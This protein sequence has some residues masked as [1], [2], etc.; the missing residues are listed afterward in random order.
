[1]EKRMADI[2]PLAE[3]LRSEI[4][5][6]TTEGDQKNNGALTADVL[7][8]VVRVA[9]TGRDLILSLS[10]NPSNLAGMI[11]PPSSFFGIGQGGDL[12]DVSLEGSVPN[13]QAFS[14]SSPSENFGMVA[15]REIISAMKNINGS[16]AKLVEALAIAREK[17]LID[18][19]KDLEAQLGVGKPVSALPSTVKP[20]TLI[21][22]V[23]GLTKTTLQEAKS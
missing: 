2:Q 13:Y 12:G 22:A 15:M 18:V 7:A 6:L 8:R 3:A 9:K 5:K 17:G 19:A 14:P 21:S 16:P 1:M 10:M 4:L 11:K 20:E 23:E